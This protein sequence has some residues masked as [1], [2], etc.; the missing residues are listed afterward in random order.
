M[1]WIFSQWFAFS[2]YWALRCAFCWNA[3]VAS[4]LPKVPLSWCQPQ[5]NWKWTWHSMCHAY[6]CF[7]WLWDQSLWSS[8]T[9][10]CSYAVYTWLPSKQVPYL[11]NSSIETCRNKIFPGQCCRNNTGRKAP[12]VY[13]PSYIDFVGRAP[14]S[15]SLGSIKLFPFGWPENI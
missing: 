6:G 7:Q 11:M 12:T 9:K 3:Q 10:S 15:C 1:L 14:T 4:I 13:S 5:A 2:S 8:G